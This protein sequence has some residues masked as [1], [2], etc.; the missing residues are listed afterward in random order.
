MRSLVV[1]GLHNWNNSVLRDVGSTGTMLQ[2]LTALKSPPKAFGVSVLISVKLP[3]SG[4]GLPTLTTIS[5][6]ARDGYLRLVPLH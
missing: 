1:I 3:D 2:A 6:F 4:G 5:L